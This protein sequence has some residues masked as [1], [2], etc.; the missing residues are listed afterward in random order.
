[1]RLLH[2][3][4]LVHEL[5]LKTL[6]GQEYGHQGISHVAAGRIARGNS[7]IRPRRRGDDAGS[8]AAA[9]AFARALARMV[10][11]LP[12]FAGIAV[13]CGFVGIGMGI[14]IGIGIVFIAFGWCDVACRDMRRDIPGRDGGR[15]GAARVHESKVD[16][17]GTHC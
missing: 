11:A 12:H 8:T 5:C 9:I 2:K 13:F 17:Q 4:N 15:N 6:N 14:G 16:E 1:M 7:G 10:V 3:A